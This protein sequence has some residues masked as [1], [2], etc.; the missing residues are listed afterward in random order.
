MDY[1]TYQ[2]P[3]NFTD[4]GRAFGQFPLRNALEAA[5]LALP[6]AALCLLYLPVGLSLRITAALILAVPLG[7]FALMGIG[8]DSLGQYTRSWIRWLW[9]RKIRGPAGPPGRNPCAPGARPA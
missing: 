3:A 2:I 4:A 9:G 7:G 8:G 6:P 5:V 1:E